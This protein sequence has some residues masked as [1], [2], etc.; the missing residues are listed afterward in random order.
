MNAEDEDEEEE[1]VKNI[2]WEPNLKLKM[3]DL[4]NNNRFNRFSFLKHS[5]LET[6]LIFAWKE[7]DERKPIVDTSQVKVTGDMITTE[8][9]ALY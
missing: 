5:Y 4:R 1:D 3:I 9:D 2:F 8:D 6:V 7:S